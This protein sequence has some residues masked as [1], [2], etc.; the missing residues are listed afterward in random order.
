MNKKYISKIV[1]DDT[2]ITQTDVDAGRLVLRQRDSDGHLIP[3]KQQITIDLDVDS[4]EHFKQL[5]GEHGYRSLIN[6]ILKSSL[7]RSQL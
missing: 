6:E 2:P 5:A 7:D 4:I 3:S 1:G